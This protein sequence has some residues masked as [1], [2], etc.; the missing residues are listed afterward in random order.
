MGSINVEIRQKQK[1]KT[2]AAVTAR[3]ET[4]S[5]QGITGKAMERDPMLRKLKAEL[6]KA[7]QRLN[8]ITARDTHVKKVAEEKKA[9]STKKG[10]GGGKGKGK[11]DAKPEKKGQKKAKKGK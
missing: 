8:A 5:E 4:L 10:K 2:V 11:K 9:P 1:E 7:N 6:K 3:E